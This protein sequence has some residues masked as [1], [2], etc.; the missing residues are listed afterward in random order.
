MSLP[1]GAVTPSTVVIGGG[2][3]GSGI[4][5][6]LLQAGATVW[7]VEADE[8]RAAQAQAR[9]QQGLSLAFKR[10]ADPTAQV[11][12]AMRRLTA[13]VG[14]PT[15]LGPALVIETVPERSELKASVLAEASR[16][17]PDAVIATNTSALSVT[18]LA[19]SVEGP[20]RFIGMHFFNPVPRS[21]LIELVLGPETA[22]QTARSATGWV[23][24]LGKESIEVK[25][26]PGFA[27]S[28][29]GVL[30]GLEAVRMVEE[31]VASAEAI[32]RGMKLGYRHPMGPLEL[33]DLVGLDVRLAIA[34]DLERRLGPRFEPPELLRDMVAR[35]D[36]GKKSGHG[37]YDWDQP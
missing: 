17:W 9:V 26:S 1:D 25:D 22:E 30:L 32:D 34:E 23:E 15:A 31:G 29:L 20:S 35:G 19:R 37:F 13:F 8:L 11:T 6:S 27:T 10:E 4:A 2:T 36:L 28:R 21:A 33:S 18:D 16:L 5:Q 12:E 24:R 7:L 14:L 3:M